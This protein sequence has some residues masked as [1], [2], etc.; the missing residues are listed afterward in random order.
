MDDPTMRIR[1]YYRV[2]IE[3]KS[4]LSIG[5]ADSV[6]TDCDLVLDSRGLPMIPATSLCGAL[7]ARLTESDARD[8][9]G[10]LDLGEGA[11]RVYE[12]TFVVG[13]NDAVGIR[14]NVSLEG[15]VARDGLK[16]DREVANKGAR[17]LTIIEVVR[18]MGEDS[19]ASRAD[20]IAPAAESMVESLLEELDCGDIRLGAKKTR[21]LGRVRVTNCQKLSFRLREDD[22]SVNAGAMREWLGFDPFDDGAWKDAE[23]VG[24]GSRTPSAGVQLRLKL[25]QAGGISIREYSTEPD[26]YDFSQMSIPGI[27]DKSSQQR[28]KGAEGAEER[29]LPGGA[30][31]VPVIPGTSWAGAIRERYARHADSRAV[32]LLFGKVEKAGVARSLIT[33]E[34]SVLSGGEWKEYTRNAVDRFTGGT[35]D[36]ALFTQRSY[37]GGMG[38]LEIGIGLTSLSG[39]KLDDTPRL[40]AGDLVPLVIALAD[41]HNGFLAVGG[42]ASIGHGLFRIE[43]AS[44]GSGSGIELMVDG[45]DRSSDFA[46]AFMIPAGVDTGLD[47]IAPDVWAAAR[48]LAGEDEGGRP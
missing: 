4:A 47:L 30:W 29:T 37:F 5:A 43:G 44:E 13:S 48:I 18:D 39:V 27:V 33:F 3:L 40:R 35:I 23:P 14:D 8:L 2:E 46:R 11:V 42:L 19:T 10:D 41:L 26:S 7:R 1:I 36:H 25:R 15:K 45:V 21:G 32:D 22:G 16:F 31:D 28:T 6:E 17:F 38:T 9:F 12:G 34:E 20:G 24:M